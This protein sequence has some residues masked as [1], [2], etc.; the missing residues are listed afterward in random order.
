MSFPENV[1]GLGVYF[2]Q[3]TKSYTM[4]TGDDDSPPSAIYDLW[5]VWLSV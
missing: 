1:G 4:I 5:R 3:I 2:I